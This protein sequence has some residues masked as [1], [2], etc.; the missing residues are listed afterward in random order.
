MAGASLFSSI[1]TLVVVSIVAIIDYQRFRIPN[2]IT[3]PFALSG[4]VFHYFNSGFQGLTLS[5]VGLMLGGTLLIVPYILRGFGGGDVK[6]LAAT[7]AW[8][9]ANEVTWVFI[10]SGLL[11]GSVSLIMLIQSPSVRRAALLNLRIGYVQLRGIGNMLGGEDRVEEVVLR[12]DRRN[13][14]VPFG[15]VLSVGLLLVVVWKFFVNG[16]N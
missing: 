14:A 6:L 10:L 4:L 16:G 9:G 3:A 12:E 2:A 11:L 13:R 7:G 8:I 5:F 15:V 1:I